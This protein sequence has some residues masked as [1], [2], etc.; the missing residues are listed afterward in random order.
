MH[1]H[2][3]RLFLR[4]MFVPQTFDEVI[5]P[6]VRGDLPLPAAAAP[7]LREAVVIA[8]RSPPPGVQLPCCAFLRL[9]EEVNTRGR[10]SDVSF[11]GGTYLPRKP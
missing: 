7:P 5:F 10:P 8:G 11:H 6:T 3:I 9:L 4:K 2:P 1:V